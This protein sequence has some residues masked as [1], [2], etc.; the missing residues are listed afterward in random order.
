M[1]AVTICEACPSPASA[2]GDAGP[3]LC[4]PCLEALTLEC[5]APLP[6]D[7]AYDKGYEDGFADAIDDV[8]SDL[9]KAAK[10]VLR[11]RDAKSFNQLRAAVR[12]IAPEFE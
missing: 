3:P 10:A 5:S 9:F 12:K 4:R 11:F 6:A 1:M 7:P 8:A 2:A